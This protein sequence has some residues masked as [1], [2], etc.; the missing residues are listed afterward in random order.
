MAR[1]P[2]TKKI[3]A[4]VVETDWPGVKVEY[5]C[6]FMGLKA[7]ANGVDQLQRRARAA[8]EPDR[9][10]GQGPQDRAH[11]PQHRTPHAARR[12]RRHRQAV[13]RDRARLVRATRSQ[14][15]VPIWKH[16]AVAHRIADMAA[17]TFAMD[18]IAK[19]ASAMADR[20]GY[21]IRLEAAAAKEWNTVRAWEIVDQTLQI[22]GG[23]GYETESS[24]AGPRRDADPGRAHHARLPHQPHLRGLERDHAPVHGAR[25]G[26]QA[27]AGRRRDDRSE[28]RRQREAR[29]PAEDPRLLRRLV[30]AA[31][32]ARARHAVPL[33]RLGPARH[34]TCA[35]SSAAPAS[36]RARA[37]TAWRSTRPRWSASRASCSAAS[38]SSWS[39]SRCRP[40]SRTRASMRDDRHARRRAQARRARRPLLPPG[41]APRAAARSATC[42][43]TTTPQAQP[44]RGAAS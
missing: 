22:R 30:S 36:W 11:H 26:R 31:V 20:G 32:A 4:F 41:A 21:D 2:K 1:D 39:C 44:G 23:R 3:S 24:L 38:T 15:G 43:A 19:L 14:W 28:E 40:P 42:G 29:G 12:V 37:S 5:R 17:T 35:S 13:P 7:L 6:R 33:R 10:G 8:R 9:R 16:E 27:P 34:R 25:G 18:S